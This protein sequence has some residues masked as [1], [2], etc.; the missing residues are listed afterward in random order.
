VELSDF[1]QRTIEEVFQGVKNSCEKV[2]AAGGKILSTNN[3][4][5]IDFDV[6]VTT[7]EGSESKANGGIKVWGFGVEGGGKIETTNTVVSR[8][9]FH[10]LVE[11]PDS[12]KR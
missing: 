9:K 6:A 4:S 2:T 11:L 12:R 3:A 8:I 10:V 7:A 1:I 5:T